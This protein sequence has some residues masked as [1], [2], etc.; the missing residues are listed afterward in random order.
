V[1]L[2]DTVRVQKLI[3]H[4]GYTS[5][6]NAEEL[7]REGRVRVNG[8]IVRE[9]GLRVA[10]DAV[11][12]VDGK[13]VNRD[14][15]HVYLMLNKPRGYICA[16]SDPF[17]RKTISHLLLEEH[18]MLGIFNIGRLDYKSEGLLI[19]T[20][21]GEF[22]HS[23]LHPSGNI[24]KKYEVTV[25]G[26]IPYNLIARWKNGVYIKGEKYHIVDF[27]DLGPRRTIISLR[28]GKNREIRRLFEHI[29]LKVLRL[30]RIAIGLLT[31]GDLPPGKYR[32]LTA[33]EIKKLTGGRLRRR[34]I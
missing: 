27:E 30:R 2:Q 13:V 14:V 19:L 9:L 33:D 29:N 17:N 20:N 1:N 22:A 15:P 5:R 31:L 18:R 24:V 3:S 34:D 8:S 28:E 16:R 4:Y 26:D 21:D 6:R 10:R 23:I 25:S 32:H 7:I 12:E 11:V